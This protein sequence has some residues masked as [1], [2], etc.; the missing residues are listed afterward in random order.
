MDTAESHP[1]SNH[2]KQ[3]AYRG[4]TPREAPGDWQVWVRL[5]DG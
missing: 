1:L 2:N 3:F 5:L 4:S